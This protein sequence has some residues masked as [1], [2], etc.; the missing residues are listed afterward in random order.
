MLDVLLQQYYSGRIVIYEFYT[1]SI[2]FN[3]ATN[4]VQAGVINIDANLDFI[5]QSG[6]YKK[7]S[8]AAQTASGEL[9]S[10]ATVLITDTG[11]GK[12][13]SNQP[14][15]VSTMFGN[16]QFPFV[17]PEPRLVRGKSTLQIQVQEFDGSTNLLQLNFQGVNIIDKGPA[18]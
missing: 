1:Y 7:D 13:F 16:G 5:I 14:I 6:T 8:G 10:D 12:Q 15:Y 17:W 18:N 11:T 9:I 3:F 4:A 2:L